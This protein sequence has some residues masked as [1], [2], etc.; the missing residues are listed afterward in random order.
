MQLKP[1]TG[2]YAGCGLDIAALNVEL[3]L[4]TH[5]FI[6]WKLQIPPVLNQVAYYAVL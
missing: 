6:F 1:L 5:G 4:L 2:P 3:H